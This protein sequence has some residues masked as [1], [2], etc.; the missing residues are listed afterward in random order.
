[1]TRDF[2]PIYR[3]ECRRC[4]PSRSKV[5]QNFRWSAG[6]PAGSCTAA[7]REFHTVVDANPL[8]DLENLTKI[9]GVMVRG[10]WISKDELQEM[11]EGVARFHESK[12]S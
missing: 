9:S 2:W 5:Q 3:L 11:A 10:R 4:L 7:H 1:M 12:A 8:D 6:T